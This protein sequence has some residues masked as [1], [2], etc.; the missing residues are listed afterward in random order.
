MYYIRPRQD[1]SL[2]RIA[3]AM[4]TLVLCDFE[5]HLVEYNKGKT[6]EILLRVDVDELRM[7][8]KAI[9]ILCEDQHFVPKNF[10][11]I[12]LSMAEVLVEVDG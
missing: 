3:A 9:A 5:P 7:N 6:Q 8:E 1:F 2:A 12:E 4:R 11:I 10:R